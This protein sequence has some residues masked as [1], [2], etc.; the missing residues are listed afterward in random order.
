MSVLAVNRAAV[1][2]SG[3]DSKALVEL[4]GDNNFLFYL[5][6]LMLVQSH[7]FPQM[8]QELRGLSPS[9]H[10]RAIKSLGF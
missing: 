9:Q 3:W 2:A 4:S 7:M 1:A 10:S 6:Q 5:L 8:F